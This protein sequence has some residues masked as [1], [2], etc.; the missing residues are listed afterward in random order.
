MHRTLLILTLAL[1]G[2]CFAQ[3][4]HVI[5]SVAELSASIYNSKN[6]NSEFDIV[7][8]ITHNTR[9]IPRAKPQK[10]SIMD[11]TG[12]CTL[13][14]HDQFNSP[15]FPGD[16]INAKG[17]LKQYPGGYV[18]ASIS[19]IRKIGHGKPPLPKV[20]TA[21]EINN[22]TFLDHLVTV[23]GILSDAS[24][25]E[26]DPRYVYA[27]VTDS[28]GPV[29]V[30]FFIEDSTQKTKLESMV[31]AK[32]SVIGICSSHFH[33]GGRLQMGTELEISDMSAFN[34]LG[35]RAD[36]FD[37]PALHTPSRQSNLVRAGDLRP[38]KTI[39]KVIATWQKNQILIRNTNGS[40]TKALLVQ[41][42]HLPQTGDTIEA[43][44]MP[45]TDLYQLNLS[46][47]IWRKAPDCMVT[48]LPPETVSAP[49]MLTDGRGNREVKVQYSGR[50][51][52]LTGLVRA[53]PAVGNGDYRLNL[54]CDGFDVPVDFSAVPAALEKI[55]DGCAIEATGVCVIETENWRPQTP[56][57]RAKGFSVIMRSPEDVRI[58]SR[59]PFWTP[60]RLT[61]VIG[62]LLLA[63]VGIGIWNRILRRIVDRRSRQLAH[64]QLSRRETEL[65]ID[66]RTHLAVELHDSISQ[67]L[68]GVALEIS[69]AGR[70]ADSDRAAARRHLNLAEKT[71]KSCR[72]ELKNCLWDLRNN[73]L[74]ETDINA[75]IRR[76]L[77]PQIG[78]T[79]LTVR[80]DVRRK[81]FTE[82]TIHAILRIIRE[83]AVNAVRHGNATE[84]KVAGSIEDD[85][86]LFSV[87]DNGCGFDPANR[88][89]MAQGH[90]G[91]QGVKERVK[92]FA[93]ELQIES[94]PGTGT[95]VTI[96]L[97]LPHEKGKKL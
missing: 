69:A 75:A 12:H 15:H 94:A 38:R 72:N 96:A 7:A 59:P 92:E 47:A 84:I 53:L 44:G 17:V 55:A 9:G 14:W 82:N 1:S 5:R 32:V 19:S 11:A 39:G 52:R 61:V 73:M 3:T 2:L 29:Y 66:E 40:I 37:A 93:G 46:K 36:P 18:Y 25:D 43:V 48:D 51:I 30:P 63:L 6:L 87:R 21:A 74:D 79:H 65:R 41:S 16:I 56:F 50:V 77:S 23:S 95:K 71:L 28:S 60:L 45:E 88:P 54:N 78:D 91:L 62:A 64:E 34:V 4:N 13:H 33:A 24:P 70:A 26:I 22:D 83:L 20:A 57:P 97:Q 85:R 81:Q 68:T 8:T 10:I 86:L 27:V 89:G 76:T 35:S 31:G 67:N 80:F 58:V 49:F 90:F 42:A